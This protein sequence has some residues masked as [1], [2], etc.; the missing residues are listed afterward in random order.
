[1]EFGVFGLVVSRLG[2]ISIRHVAREPCLH[3][4]RPRTVM[5]QARPTSPAPSRTEN[6]VDLAYEKVAKHMKHVVYIMDSSSTSCIGSIGR[7]RVITRGT[8]EASR[9]FIGHT[10]QRGMKEC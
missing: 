10:L 2:T 1:M 6:R 9:G 7:G 3:W 8:G 5:N 4:G